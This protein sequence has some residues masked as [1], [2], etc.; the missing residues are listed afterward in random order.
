LGKKAVFSFSV[1]LIFLSLTAASCNLSQ[2]LQPY[3][4]TDSASNEMAIIESYSSPTLTYLKNNQTFTPIFSTP[5]PS[6]SESGFSPQTKTATIILPW[7]PCDGVY[8]SRLQGNMRAQV[9]DN[10]P[11]SNRVRSGAGTSFKILGNIGPGEIVNI[12]DGPACSNNLVWWR[13]LSEETN[14]EGWTSEGD[15]ESYWLI[16]LP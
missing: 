1:I 2:P 4:V 7:F 9:S 16:P 12:V 14:L 15:F 13:V 3:S 5:T 10:P 8:D 11:L 6:I